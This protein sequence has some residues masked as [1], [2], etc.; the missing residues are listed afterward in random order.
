MRTQMKNIESNKEE[1]LSY[2]AVQSAPRERVDLLA[3]F[4]NLLIG[5]AGSAA[6]MAIGAWLA[7]SLM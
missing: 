6:L 2:V 7:I 1:G 5:M 4:Q 3:L